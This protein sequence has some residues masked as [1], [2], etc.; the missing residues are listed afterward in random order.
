VANLIEE[1]GNAVLQ[2]ASQA[3]VFDE[4]FPI[5]ISFDETYSLIDMSVVQVANA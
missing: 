1:G 2:F 4:M 5:D 3:L